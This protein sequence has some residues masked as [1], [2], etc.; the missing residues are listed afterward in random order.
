MNNRSAYCE[1][2]VTKSMLAR[3]RPMKRNSM[4]LRALC[5]ITVRLIIAVLAIATT[6]STT[7]VPIHARVD[8]KNYSRAVSTDVERTT[9]EHRIGKRAMSMG[10]KSDKSGKKWA[11]EM[12]IKG[13]VMQAGRDCELVQDFVE[14]Q[15]KAHCMLLRRGMPEED[16]KTFY[17]IHLVHLTA[18]VQ[19]NAKDTQ[20]SFSSAC[21]TLTQKRAL[22]EEIEKHSVY[23]FVADARKLEPHLFYLPP[24]EFPDEML[25]NFSKKEK[26]YVDGRWLMTKNAMTATILNVNVGELCKLPQGVRILYDPNNAYVLRDFNEQKFNGSIEVTGADFLECTLAIVIRME[27]LG[28]PRYQSKEVLL[29]C[30][31][32]LF[33]A[34]R[35]TR[36]QGH[37]LI[38]PGTRLRYYEILFTK[39]TENLNRTRIPKI[40]LL[41]IQTHIRKRV[42]M[43]L[44][45]RSSGSLT[46]L[47]LKA[48]MS[49]KKLDLEEMIFDSATLAE[50]EF[51]LLKMEGAP[52]PKILTPLPN[53]DDA[54]AFAV[55]NL[56]HCRTGFWEYTIGATWDQRCCNDIC[57]SVTSSSFIGF[58]ISECCADCNQAFC[59]LEEPGASLKAAV[60]VI[61]YSFG[62][63]PT[64]VTRVTI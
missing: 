39:L 24:E 42:S 17:G 48:D 37:R 52:V 1:Q 33:N 47:V 32:T 56:H 55:K 64:S 13:A 8:S 10:T 7:A 16:V 26:R 40:P 59:N 62:I 63:F 34:V 5:A 51:E 15:F 61:S 12:A 4:R 27:M 22:Q 49:L 30:V 38:L 54:L 21:V 14:R 43:L 19:R 6:K 23:Q 58:S 31:E 45:Y 9:L 46:H 20:Q 28:V 35:A 41:M 50:M 60:S 11:D 3:A 18:M 29:D 25:G 57:K 53:E 2:M 44:R 36:K